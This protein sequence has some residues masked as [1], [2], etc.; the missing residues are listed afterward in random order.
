MPFAALFAGNFLPDVESG[1]REELR[2]ATYPLTLGIGRKLF[3]PD[4]R[5]DFTTV[6]SILSST[7]VVDDLPPQRSLSDRAIL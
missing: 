3:G 2:L 4:T 1:V 5:L 7:G 6:D